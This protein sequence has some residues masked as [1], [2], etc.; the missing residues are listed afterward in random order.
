MGLDMYLFKVKREEVAYWRKANAIHAWFENNVAD[1]NLENCKDYYVSK[2][3]LIKLR[4]TCKEVINKSNLVYGMVKN[5]EQLTQAGWKQLYETGKVIEDPSVAQELLPTQ[6]G[7]FFGGTDY[8]QYYI[9]DLEETIE[10]IN[11]ILDTVDFE[12][13][14][15]VYNAWW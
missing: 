15:I 3:D 14:D 2:E 9:N 10:Q 8:N 7:F 1:G 11:N 12:K 5:G 4:D 6:S 13:Y